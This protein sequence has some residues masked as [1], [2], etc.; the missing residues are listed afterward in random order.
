MAGTHTWGPREHANKQCSDAGHFLRGVH[1]CLPGRGKIQTSFAELP[2]RL[3][4]TVR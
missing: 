4:Q 3:G 2:N 1:G